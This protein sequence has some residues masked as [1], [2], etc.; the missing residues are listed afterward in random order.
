MNLLKNWYWKN[1]TR[2]RAF[3]DKKIASYF[4]KGIYLTEELKIFEHIDV[5]DRLDELERVF[6]IQESFRT[7]NK[8]L[9]KL[10]STQN[11]RY[12]WTFNFRLIKYA[13]KSRYGFGT[14]KPFLWA[15]QN[16]ATKI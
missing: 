13:I 8:R 12:L 6:V 4:F 9:F 1:Q 2:E 3:I 16:L 15:K 5:I 14:C 11:P 7:K 10:D